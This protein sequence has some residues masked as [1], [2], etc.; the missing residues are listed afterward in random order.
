MVYKF[1]NTLKS[2]STEEVDSDHKEDVSDLEHKFGEFILKNAQTWLV[3]WERITFAPN[4]YSKQFSL[5]VLSALKICCFN[6]LSGVFIFLLIGL[7][8]WALFFTGR[9]LGHFS[10][11]QYISPIMFCVF[12][13]TISP[14]FSTATTVIPGFISWIFLKLA[15]GRLWLA[16]HVSRSV[17]CTNMEWLNAFC[18]AS[19]IFTIDASRVFFFLN[20]TIDQITTPFFAGL[21]LIR[22]YYVWL[23]WKMYLVIHFPDSV[24]RRLCGLV[25]VGTT[26]MFAGLYYIGLYYILYELEL[27]HLD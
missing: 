20:D 22:V 27:G 14:L 5:S 16:D 18:C 19:I 11:D 9:F 26:T 17:V 7:I 8:Y 2:N 25:I 10:G 6:F 12:L 13:G 15:G 24:N 3:Y 1:M 23:Q 21:I 4:T